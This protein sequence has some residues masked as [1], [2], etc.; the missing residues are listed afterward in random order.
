PCPGGTGKK[1][2]F[3]C[4]DMMG[5]L[6]KIQRSLEGDQRLAC[7]EHVEKT[8]TKYPDRACLLAIKSLLHSEM[9]Q[10]E[11]LVETHDLFEEKYPGNPVALAER[12]IHLATVG[13]S[14]E[15]V[16]ALQ[17]AIATVDKQMPTRLY[18]AIGL[19]GR[20]LLGDGNIL[21]AVAHLLLQAA[22]GGAEDPR[23]MSLLAPIMRSTEI[24]LLLRDEHHLA[25]APEGA[26]YQAEMAE[27]QNL[28]MRGAWQLAVDRLSELAKQH[29]D[30]P[31]ILN[32]IGTLQSWLGQTRQAVSA[33][34]SY[35][36]LGSVSPDDAI[37]AEAMAQLVDPDIEQPAVDLVCL[38]FE[39]ADPEQ[40]VALFTA[41]PSTDQVPVESAM[42]L[43]E[44]G[45][46]PPQAIFLLLDKAIP[47]PVESGVGIDIDAVPL[48]IGQCYLYGRQTDRE[49][50]LE[51]VVYEDN[52]PNSATVLNELFGDSIKPTD[53]KQVLSSISEAQ[54]RLS[55]DWRLP[56]DIPATER[57]DLI[58]RKH[59]RTLFDIWTALPNPVF[60]GKTP[61]E[62]ANSAEHRNP[63]LAA[64]LIL[65][66]SSGH[67]HST[68][69]YDQLRQQLGLP[70]T[71]S[72]DPS[73]IDMRIFPLVRMSRVEVEQMDD[74]QLL[75]AFQR[76][77]M[78]FAG[79]AIRRLAPEVLARESLEGKINKAEVYGVLSGQV[80]S[81]D[82]ALELLNKAQAA[83]NDAGESPAPWLL[84]ELEIRLSRGESV[85]VEHLLRQLQSHHFNEPN[86]AQS[87]YEL[88]ARFGIIDPR[89]GPAAMATPPVGAMP[90]APETVPQ[91]SDQI[92]TPDSAAPS[93]PKKSS[94]WTPDD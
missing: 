56:N 20:A 13:K 92:W 78:M 29:A 88:L 6:E 83:S 87:V 59:R 36:A 65:E 45:Q 27:V 40:L 93:N 63:L 89:T 10:E 57:R 85:E 42:P 49:A 73:G 74:E 60:D 7:L 1:I 39:T 37:E 54:R 11:A 47:E 33:W 44:E 62:A 28:A 90:S 19:L 91:T 43:E 12:A 22:I 52:L 8:L 77:A 16:V 18:E 15:G 24:P 69:D 53:D 35:A 21:A 58:E 48:V 51:F 41:N 17:V 86:I 66:M 84:A 3:C 5:E 26:A 81:S 9:K 82:E 76:A 70:A 38:T 80:P 72:I 23:A 31:E 30:A 67:S 75:V 2:K 32:N 34:R 61:Q 14:A 64:I 79:S 4:S 55:W 25:K 94:I 46:P 50:R 68:L 71:T